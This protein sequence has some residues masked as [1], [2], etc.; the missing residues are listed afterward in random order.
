MAAAGFS[1]T[2]PCVS[3]SPLAHADVSWGSSRVLTSRTFVGEDYVRS[4]KANS[5]QESSLSPS[6]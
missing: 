3:Y 2:N 5:P 1:N 6:S 4:K